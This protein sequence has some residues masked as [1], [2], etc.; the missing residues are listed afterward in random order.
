MASCDKREIGNPQSIAEVVVDCTRHMQNTETRA[1]PSLTKVA[2]GIQTEITNKM[3][4]ILVSWLIEVHLK[5][6]LLPETLYIAVNMIDRYCE[7][8]MVSRSH[9]Q[10][11]GITALLIACKYEEIIVPPLKNFIEMT[12]NAYDRIQVINQEW[13]ILYTLEYEITFPTAYRFLERFA[14]LGNCDEQTFQFACYLCELTTI[15]V[16]M[17]RWPPSKVACSAIYLAKKMLKQEQCWNKTMSKHSNYSV[18]EVREC[19][20]HLVMLVNAA[21][22]NSEMKP[23]FNKYST[24]KYL[25]V[26]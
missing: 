20:R 4:Q 7:R 17:N 6:N 24:K 18:K 9:Y 13:K 1:Q 14:R 10:L 22:T 23:V 12:D 26:A 15:E 21:P 8:Q 2:G 19:A 5:F 3:R 11:L 25:R 16:T